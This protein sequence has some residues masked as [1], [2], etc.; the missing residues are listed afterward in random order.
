MRSG[1]DGRM[2]EAAKRVIGRTFSDEEKSYWT[3][4]S[5]DAALRLCS[6]LVVDENAGF[7][8]A[9]F[10]YWPKDARI[11]ERMDFA[12][13]ERVDLHGGPILHV[14]LYV[15][16]VPSFRLVRGFIKGLNPWGVTCHRFQ[17]GEFVFKAQKN[18]FF[19]DGGRRDG[20]NGWRRREQEQF[21]QQDKFPN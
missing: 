9:F 19:V 8:L 11:V 3:E 13:L 6:G 20:F 1:N 21:Q 10:R 2:I 5:I 17:G 7:A 16:P 4:G 18:R 14:L 15:A 12:E